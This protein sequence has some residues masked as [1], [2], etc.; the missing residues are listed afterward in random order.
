MIASS[1]IRGDLLRRD[2]RVGIGHG[3]DNR[4]RRHRAD[5]GV[6]E[7]ALGGEAED[8]VGAVHGVG[9]RA[10]VGLDGVRGLP[11]VHALGAA[12]VDHAL[13]VAEDDVFGREC[14]SP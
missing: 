2:L 5:H 14:P 11:L 10:R 12:L 4:V 1:R 6:G 3:E 7:R 8:D 9:E 13:G